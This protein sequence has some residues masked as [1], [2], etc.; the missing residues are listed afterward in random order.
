VKHRA[1]F[2]DRDGVINRM[3]YHAE[4]G[5]VDSPQ[6][7]AEFEILPGAA[8]A[9]RRINELGLL[10]VVVSNQPGVAKGKCTLAG[11]DA[12]TDRLHT[13]LAAAGAHLD[14]V[15]CCLHHPEALVADYRVICNCRK[16]HPGLLQRAAEEHGIDLLASF[17]IGDGLTD[18][19]AGQAVGCTT[20]FLG[21]HKCDTCRMMEGQGARPDYIL[22]SLFDAVEFIGNILP[23]QEGTNHANLP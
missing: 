13:E 5:L 21:D 10:A 11:L 18:V 1:I 3:V 17:M 16:P 4:F 7:A 2:L 19:L 23:E 20:L 12:I 8:A 9:I 22:P 15:Y 6:N 14:A